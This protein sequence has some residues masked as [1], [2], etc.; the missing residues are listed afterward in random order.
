VLVLE[1]TEVVDGEERVAE[2]LIP[3]VD[4]YIDAVDRAQRRITAD[5]H[6]DY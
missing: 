4:T 3:F 5:W 6:K 2:R 1:H